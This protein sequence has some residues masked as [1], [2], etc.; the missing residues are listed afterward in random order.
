ML[1]LKL[2]STTHFVMSFSG[3]FKCEPDKS[4][5]PLC[6]DSLVASYS[7]IQIVVQVHANATFQYNTVLY[8]SPADASIDNVKSTQCSVYNCENHLNTPQH[9]SEILSHLR[10]H[11]NIPCYYETGNPNLIFP[12]EET[13]NEIITKLVIFSISTFIGAILVFMSLCCCLPLLIC[14]QKYL[15]K[16]EKYIEALQV[17]ALTTG[18]LDK[19]KKSITEED[20]NKE[21]LYREYE[22]LYHMEKELYFD[23]KN[24]HSPKQKFPPVHIATI[25][26]HPHVLYY[27]ISCGADTTIRDRDNR[28][29]LHYALLM[30][31]SKLI[32]ILIKG[33]CTADCQRYHRKKRIRLTEAILHCDIET[34]K[35]LIEVGFPI[36]DDSS[37]D[38]D[39]P[40]A[41]YR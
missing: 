2:N 19:V 9:I 21:L 17:L 5:D 33:G 29:A 4:C 16:D 24:S 12:Y 39:Q 18:D 41:V 10:S 15:N 30:R 3:E 31:N 28:T 32:R 38:H 23:N 27:L 34:I 1:R 6:L 26:N 40:T 13:W 7:C 14:Y 37:I 11:V 25:H 22:D 35:L 20:V 36:T 8:R